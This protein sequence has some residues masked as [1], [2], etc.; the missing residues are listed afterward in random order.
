MFTPAIS[1][2]THGHFALKHAD[3]F[4]NSFLVFKNPKKDLRGNIVWE[5]ARNHINSFHRKLC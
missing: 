2:Y 4:R 1:G 5:I 3:H